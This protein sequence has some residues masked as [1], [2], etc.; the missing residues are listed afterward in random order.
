MKRL[1]FLS[2]LVL[3]AACQPNAWMGPED[4]PTAV[5]MGDSL[6]YQADGEEGLLGAELT[7]AGYRHWVWGLIGSTVEEGYI[8]YTTHTN[9][10]L[11]PHDTLVIAL[12]T[13]DVGLNPLDPEGLSRVPLEDSRASLRTWLEVVSPE[14]CVRI[15]GVNEGAW[16]WGLDEVGPAFNAMLAEEADRRPNTEF[17]P[18]LADPAWM[19]DGDVHMLQPGRDAYRS[20]LVSAVESCST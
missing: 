4:G 5:V 19:V 9:L 2:I 3:L 12:G 15:V 16:G 10:S 14:T 8:N 6:T 18:F 20:L 17:I 7:A 1:W 11:Y 13:N